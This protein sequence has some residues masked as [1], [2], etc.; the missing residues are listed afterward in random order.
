MK[1]V[2]LAAAL[3]SASVVSAQPQRRALELE[4]CHLNQVT[5]WAECGSFEVPEDYAVPDGRRITLRVAVLPSLTQPAEPDPMFML[6]GG[7]G[8]S[9]V[10]IAA[11]V[12]QTLGV[13]NRHRDI[14][15]IDQ[16]GT[17]ESTPLECALDFDGTAFDPEAQAE[18]VG[19]CLSGLDADPTSYT[20]VNHFRDL[21]AV[22][23]ALGYQR[24]NLYAGSYGTRVAQVY[25]RERPGALQAVVMDAVASMGMRVGLEMGADAQL[26]LDGLFERCQRNLACEQRFPDLQRRFEALLADLRASPR[27]LELA[28]AATGEPGIVEMD[29]RRF[30]LGLR[31]LLYSPQTQRLVPLL[32]HQA[33]EGNWLGLVGLTSSFT[34]RLLEVMNPGLMLAVLCSEDLADIEAA[35][36]PAAE[37]TSFVG[38]AQID[39]FLGYCAAW[40]KPT[41]TVDWTPVS[42][43]ELP[44]L[45][46]SGGL[47]PVTPPYRAEEVAATLGNSRH[48]IV[49]AGGHTVGGTGCISRLIAEF[50][51]SRDPQ[52][53]DASCIDDI[54][55]PSFFVSTLGPAS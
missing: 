55:F 42:N 48:L 10:A 1:T 20:T 50:I 6:A 23:R 29:D 37:R 28:D 32:I 9:A 40:P 52:G 27:R 2:L 30:A 11:A 39:E 54:A 36:I 51:D 45:L 5:D 47:D 4:R 43:D 35:D 19:D 34:Q 12:Q 46:L 7:P 24:I 15:L 8:Q 16:R 41:R 22:R 25:M 3:L 38:T 33:A 18:A 21:D 49:P 53:L 17:G 31:A 44:V 13:V 26:A 14:V